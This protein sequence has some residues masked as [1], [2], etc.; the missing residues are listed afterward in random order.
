MSTLD[1]ALFGLPDDVEIDIH[2]SYGTT[3]RLSVGKAKTMRSENLHGLRPS[4]DDLE[5]PITK[6]TVLDMYDDL[7]KEVEAD[8]DRI[9]RFRRT[10]KLE[11]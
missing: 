7:V 11:D 8:F 5:L 3:L 10:I 4:A 9:A 2:T 6:Q 1:P